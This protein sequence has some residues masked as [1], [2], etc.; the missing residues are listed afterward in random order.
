MDPGRNS[1]TVQFSTIRRLRSAVNNYSHTTVKG[2]AMAALASDRSARLF[3]SASPTNSLFFSHFSTGCHNRMGDVVIRDRALTIDEVAGL[4]TVLELH[5]AESA[6]NLSLR[7]EVA[8]MGTVITT[9]FS[10]AVRGEELGHCLL[11]ET[12][13]DT[14]LG[15]AHVRRP[16]VMLALEGRFKGVQGRKQ[17]RF[18]LVPE[19]ASGVLKNEVWLVRLMREYILVHKV[20][21]T[22]PLFRLTP[23]SIRAASIIELDVLFHRYLR[24]V[25]QVMTGV[26]DP[27][28]P[29]ERDYSLRR[30]LRRGSNTHAR[31]RDIPVDVIEANNRW[32]KHE[33]AGNREPS[34]SMVDTYTDVVAGLEFGLKYSRDL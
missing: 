6:G 17:H 21:L 9:G 18:P 23:E 24:E 27:S 3:F 4:M 10:T 1:T 22:G 19:S 8:L 12:A 31:N 25:Q 33:R 26:I 30:S 15:L 20:A 14:N 29:V 28:V 32:R 16:H 11:Y 13:M 5:W 2:M 34:L 7:F